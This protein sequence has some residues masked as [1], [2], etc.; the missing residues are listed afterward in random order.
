MVDGYGGD[1]E[2][3]GGGSVEV[4]SP[5]AWLLVAAAGGTGGG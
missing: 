3:R 2:R 5:A 1:G 4:G